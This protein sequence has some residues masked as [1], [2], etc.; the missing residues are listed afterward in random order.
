[1][2]GKPA[3]YRYLEVVRI[4]ALDLGTNSFHLLVA[5]VYPDGHFEAIS[6]EKEMIRLGDVV[7]RE[8]RITDAAADTAVATVERFK[9]IA[10]A[11]GAIELHAC[12][13]SAIR[14]AS[15]GDA[16]VDRIESETGVGVEV[17]S[18]QREAELIFAA[19]RA[20]VL[21][22]PAPALCFDLG[23]GSVEIMVG[24]AGGLRWATSENLGVARLTAEF[25]S[26]DPISKDD[27]RRLRAHVVDVLT[28]VANAVAAFEPKLFVGSSGTFGD[29][30][31]M[32]AARRAEDVPVSLNQ[33]TFDRDEFQAVHKDIL[34][35]TAA[36]RLR[37]DGLEARRVDLI[38]AGSVFLATAMELFGFEELTV[39]E[40]ALREGIV[41]DAI[42]RHD[43]AELSDDPRALRSAS[44][45]GLARRCNSDEAHARK[46]ADLA[47]TL[48]DRTQELHGLGAE[49]RELLEHAALLHDIGE[50]VSPSGH[51]KHGAYL[52]QHGR[53]RGFSP[54][55]VQLLTALARW[56]RRGTPDP[57][58]D[59]A[60]VDADRLRRLT[61]LLRVA[62][63][64]DRGR[65]GAVD[66]IQVRV[67][68]SL[69]V[70]EVH[71]VH[72]AELELWGARRKRELFEKVFG[73][74]LELTVRTAPSARVSAPNQ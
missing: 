47:L 1:M 22:E 17:I 65:S 29:L 18:G 33:L 7:N 37:F 31:H 6:R 66:G 32:V 72:D 58:D 55:E 9:R 10:D 68:P 4:A 48:F 42:R 74:D 69:V 27:R 50:H 51:H 43:P 26:S 5:D 56:H 11:A 19:I 2:S 16:L 34:S 53:L 73:R 23:G 57:G 14:V 13:T 54:A 46:V 20:S 59:Y 44:V 38:T 36:D 49:D 30:A 12:A 24:D 41:L 70:I 61:A 62:D 52:V 21:L 28:P 39:C 67:G 3:A 15:N 25:V 64:L 63:G 8:G 40:W 35:S 60:L 71:T 45:H